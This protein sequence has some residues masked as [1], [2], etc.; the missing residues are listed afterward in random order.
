MN[1][2]EFTPRCFKVPFGYSLGCCCACCRDRLLC[3]Y[4]LFEPRTQLQGV[5]CLNVNSKPHSSDPHVHDMYIRIGVNGTGGCLRSSDLR[6]VHSSMFISKNG[7]WASMG[8]PGHMTPRLCP[9][10]FS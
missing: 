3:T 4:V 1:Q 5:Y 8:H 9:P 10:C 6:S 7:T 2:F